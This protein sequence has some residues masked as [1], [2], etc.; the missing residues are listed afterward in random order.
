VA[1]SVVQ[2]YILDPS[3]GKQHVSQTARAM[4]PPWQDPLH[5]TR[6]GKK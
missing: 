4:A 3:Y 2:L 6:C 5:A 1:C